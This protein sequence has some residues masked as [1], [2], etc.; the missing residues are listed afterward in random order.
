MPLIFVMLYVPLEIML[1][2]NNEKIR[3]FMLKKARSMGITES[4]ELN[5]K[6]KI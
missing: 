3:N 4:V 2:N 1:F 6:K 5:L